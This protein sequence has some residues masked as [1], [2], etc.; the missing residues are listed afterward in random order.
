MKLGADFA[1]TLATVDGVSTLE[2]V[3]GDTDA[4]D[5]SVVEPAV[6]GPGVEREV[7]IP[8]VVEVT[9]AMTGVLKDGSLTV[10]EETGE[11]EDSTLVAVT[12]GINVVDF[13]GTRVLFG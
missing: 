2:N 8:G 7:A 6:E 1:L 5:S 4:V 12:E 9:L 13:T 3:L 10:N 11:M